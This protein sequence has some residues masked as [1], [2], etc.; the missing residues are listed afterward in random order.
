MTRDKQVERRDAAI[1]VKRVAEMEWPHNY[2]VK[3]VL[4]DL[5]ERIMAGDHDVAAKAYTPR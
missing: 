3:K 2:T 1:F 4:L 5:A